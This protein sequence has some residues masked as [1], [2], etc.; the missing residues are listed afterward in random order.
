MDLKEVKDNFWVMTL[1]EFK[2]I[3]INTETG[4]INLF[5]L[6]RNWR[7]VESKD[8]L[9]TWFFARPITAEDLFLVITKSFQ[10]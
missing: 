9:R 7:G 10:L 4:E 2:E 3:H 5:R 1:S 8:M 6:V